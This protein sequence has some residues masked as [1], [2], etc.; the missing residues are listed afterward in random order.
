MRFLE[1]Q[2]Q[3]DSG[4]L[5]LLTLDSEKRACVVELKNE[6]EEKQLFQGIRYYDWVKTNIAWLSR[7]HHDIDAS[8][9]P[10]LILIAPDFPDELRRVAKYT[11]LNAD[12]ALSLK[13]YHAFAVDD[14][15]K[16]VICSD[17]EIGEAPE[18][19]EIPTIEDK[20]EYIQSDKVK[21]LLQN[22]IIE[23]KGKGIEIR[24]IRGYGMSGFYK[25]K[26]FLRLY[27]RK[28][29]FVG[30]AMNLDGEWTPNVQIQTEEQWKGFFE[31]EVKPILEAIDHR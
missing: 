14:K 16:A 30:K 23:L 9:E 10:R 5:D 25:E 2:L 28:Q 7:V 22:T 11:T 1:R 27:P 26:R 12:G 3:T 13:V 24:P 19:P 18:E 15:E 20:V 29:W 4:P 31:K 17:V 21:Q 8:A 6:T